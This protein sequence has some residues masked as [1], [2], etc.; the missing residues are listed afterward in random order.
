MPNGPNR[1]AFL[2]AGRR[3][4]QQA[5]SAGTPG[6]IVG[7]TRSRVTVRLPDG[8]TVT[9]RT[10]VLRRTLRPGDRVL[11]DGRL[12]TP[13]FR[14]VAGLVDAVAPGSVTIAGVRCRL[15]EHSVVRPAGALRRG[16]HVGALCVHNERDETLTVQAVFLGG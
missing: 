11:V 6:T 16:V 4:P 1:R 3:T 14:S 7:A 12:A 15:D 9:A 10:R 2:A 5:E 13:L 8:R